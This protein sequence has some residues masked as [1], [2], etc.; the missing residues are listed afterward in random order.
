[1]YS[2][3]MY[4]QQC[5]GRGGKAALSYTTKYTSNSIL[6]D[7]DFCLECDKSVPPDAR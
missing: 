4:Q 3:S 7:N 5:Y 6:D 1:M 2:T